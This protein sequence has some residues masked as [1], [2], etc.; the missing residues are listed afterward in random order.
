MVPIRLN[1]PLRRSGTVE[2][3]LLLAA[4]FA[5]GIVLRR[6]GRLPE[7][8]HASVNGF[9]IHVSLPALVL[10]HVHGLTPEV[11]LLGR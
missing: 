6:S 9:I 11:T 3:L 8:A 7:N 10:R 4:C 5:A 2:N 1:Q